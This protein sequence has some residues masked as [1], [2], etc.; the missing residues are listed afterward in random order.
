MEIAGTLQIGSAQARLSYQDVPS[1]IRR[2]RT[3]YFRTLIDIQ[4]PATLFIEPIASR[5]EPGIEG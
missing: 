4:S 2:V 5:N 3:W 1:G